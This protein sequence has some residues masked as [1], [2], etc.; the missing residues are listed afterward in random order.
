[1]AIEYD[2][3][4]AMVIEDN[5]FIRGVIVKMLRGEKLQEVAE[6]QDGKSAIRLLRQGMVP[7]FIICDIQ[8][9]PINGLEFVEF[10]RN[11]SELRKRN[12]PVIIL[13][14]NPIKDNVLKARAYGVDAFLVKPVSRESLLSRIEHVLTNR[15]PT[16]S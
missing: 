15:R 9:A 4:R 16:S 7:D 5:E 11:D 14:A 10:I 12:T 8:M 13:T 1:M 2:K 6:A 3:L